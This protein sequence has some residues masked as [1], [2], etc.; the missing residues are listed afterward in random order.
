MK[1]GSFRL[2]EDNRLLWSDVRVMENFSERFHGLRRY[3]KLPANR[4]LWFPKCRL[5]H[6]FGMSVAMDVIGLNEQLK[7]IAVRRNVRPR[8]ILHLAGATSL[9]ECEA[10]SALPLE[11]WFGK[12]LQFTQKE[13]VYAPY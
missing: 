9:I 7:I 12:Q 8:Q 4:V 5:I 1:Q 6:S 10:G 11:Y 13:L 2:T 3:P